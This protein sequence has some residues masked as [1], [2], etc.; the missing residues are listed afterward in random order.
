[1][2]HA[3]RKKQP[4]A[5]SIVLPL[6]VALLLSLSTAAFA[7]EQPA[8]APPAGEVSP[9]GPRVGV[10]TGVGLPIGS[11]FAGSGGLSDTI[12]AYVPLRLDVGY[13]IER[14]FYVGIDGQVAAI[15][16]N[17]CTGGFRC[18]G[19]STRV[20]VMVAYHLLPT[21]VFDPYLGI[22][23][24]YE[25]LH[26]SRSFGDASVDITARG[27]E[28]ID[29]ELGADLRLGRAWRIGPV[30]SG[31]LGRYTSV[32][33]NGTTST[34]FDTLQHAWINIGVRGAFDL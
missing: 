28:L 7:D 34:D 24:G 1:M 12:A 19:T 22:G 27:F 8:A 6:A 14:H 5:V 26:T 29:A 16:P 17:G 4:R 31:S 30:V 11:A 15:I 25:V 3:W 2:N 13:R 9:T 18:S 21:K 23:I 33:V 32:A 20:G 10:R